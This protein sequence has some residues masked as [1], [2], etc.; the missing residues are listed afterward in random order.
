MYVLIKLWNLICRKIERKYKHRKQRDRFLVKLSRI[1]EKVD[2]PFIESKAMRRVLF[3]L[4]RVQV[5]FPY[6]FKLTG[7]FRDFQ[8]EKFDYNL[9]K[10]FFLI[11]VMCVVWMEFIL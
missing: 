3:A 6:N 11:V 9:L 1:V 8:L 10:L 4:S 5:E 7:T 2:R